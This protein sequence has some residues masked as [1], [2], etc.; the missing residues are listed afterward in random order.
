MR[1]GRTVLHR[2]ALLAVTA[3]KRIIGVAVLV[4]VAAAVFGVQAA[5]SLSSNGLEDPTSD[6][7]QRLHSDQQATTFHG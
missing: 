1:E 3:P 7:R 6:S 5:K 2:I 4:M